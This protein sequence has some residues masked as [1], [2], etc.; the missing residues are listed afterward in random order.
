VRYGGIVINALVHHGPYQ[1]SRDSVPDPNTQEPS[2]IVV[3]TATATT[4]GSCPHIL[5]RE[6][7][8]VVDEQ[9]DEAHVAVSSLALPHLH[10]V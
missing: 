4:C 3:E 9:R 5:N 1:P 7:S 8:T 6:G 10:R 2:E